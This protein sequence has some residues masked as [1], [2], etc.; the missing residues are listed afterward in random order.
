[1]P[2]LNWIWIT[3]FK[4]L[5]KKMRIFFIKNKL[6]IWTENWII[7]W[8]LL[9]KNQILNTIVICTLKFYSKLLNIEKIEN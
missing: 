7:F 1:M 9:G 8:L 2:F 4:K 5:K 6:S 3:I